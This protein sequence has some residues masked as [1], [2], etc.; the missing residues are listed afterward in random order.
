MEQI[1]YLTKKLF[2]SSSKHRND[3]FKEQ[4]NLFDEA[5]TTRDESAAYSDLETTIEYVPAKVTAKE[6]VSCHS[7]VKGMCSLHMSLL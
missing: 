2:G 4:L 5:E 3:D 7:I 6:Y 1:E